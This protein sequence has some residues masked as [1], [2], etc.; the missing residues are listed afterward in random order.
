MKRKTSLIAYAAVF[1]LGFA[2]LAPSWSAGPVSWPASAVTIY[3]PA[4]A[5]G[6]TDLLARVLANT[7]NKTTG[8]PFIVVNQSQGGGIVAFESTRTAKPDGN[9][10]M[11]WHTGIFVNY[12]TG[13]YNYNPLEA[14]TPLGI[15]FGGGSQA[16]IVKGNSPIS[17]IADLV[18]AAKKAP[19]T[20]SYGAQQGGSAQLVAGI[21]E[22]SADI[23]LRLVDAA[24]ETDKITG[25]MSGNIG[26]SAITSKAAK[27]YV[28]SGD[29]KVIG[30]VDGDIDPLYPDF[31][32]AV[33][34]GYPKLKWSQPLVLFAPKGMNPE[35]VSAISDVLR[36]IAD[37]PEMQKQLTNFGFKYVFTSQ[38]A[39]ISTLKEVDELV[40]EVTKSLGISVK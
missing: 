18:A 2:I 7:L 3:V 4:S 37:D 16:F 5:G 31:I 39:S 19:G 9:S 34:Q 20:I 12:Y 21:L 25:V 11:L 28:K 33:N 22:N 10:L 6:G 40:A 26:M 35:I 15:L 8:R 27:Q 24:S 14:Y 17:T 29:L 32:P 13:M 1:I 30:L 36:K 38:M 23:K